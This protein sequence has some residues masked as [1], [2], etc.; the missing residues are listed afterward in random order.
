MS[1]IGKQKIQIPAGVE[2]TV[3]DG[4][5]LITTKGP[6]GELKHVFPS[7]L[8]VFV[9]DG[10][11]VVQPNGLNGQAA[12][13]GL[14]R[15]LI[16]NMIKGVVDGFQKNLEFTGVGYKAQVKNDGIELQLGFSHPIFIKAPEGITFK[17]EKNSIAVS[18][19]DKALIGQVAAQIRT[20]RPPEPY[21]GSGIRYAGEVIRR[22]AGKKAATA[23]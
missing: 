17:A 5:F 19:I 2:V 10:F 8:K 21:K 18:G 4:R 16:A 3:D 12:L 20:L 11:I 7:S 23:G 1:R 6:K 22:K 14:T 15:A 9:E 13:W